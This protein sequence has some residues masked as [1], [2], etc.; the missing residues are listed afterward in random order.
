MIFI[1][2]QGVQGA[3]WE[4]PEP[5]QELK[6][7]QIYKIFKI[8]KKWFEALAAVG[9]KCKKWCEALSAVGH[10][11]EMSAAQM[12]G[13]NFDLNHRFLKLFVKSFLFVS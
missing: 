7:H 3:I 5:I 12:T 1:S 9:A 4:G 8:S 10:F 2:I 6:N 11:H 13:N